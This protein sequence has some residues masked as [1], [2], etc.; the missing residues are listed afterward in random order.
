MTVH[1]DVEI[2]STYLDRELGR[3]E[4]SQVEE[5]LERCDDCREKLSGLQK[6]V[7]NLQALERLAPPQ[8]LGTHLHRLA[9]LE[10]CQPTL[11]QRLE[12]RVSRFSLQPSVAPIFAIVVALIVIIYM[13]SW[14]LHRQATGRIPVHLE[15]EVTESATVEGQGMGSSRQIAGRAFT[16][17]AG[18]WIE[19]GLEGQTVA[20]TMSSSDPRA[21]AWLA[22]TPELQE[23][24]ALGD[25]V[26]LM[27][28]DRVVEIRLDT[29]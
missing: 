29:P 2:L 16:L 14:G 25:R 24:T 26:Q 13:L 23:I 17:E 19:E 18:I 11:T 4:Q 6:V 28:G 9:S 1:P 22:D 5:H 10:I 7:K 20:E 21:P 12:Q 15:S 3:R 27:M 8:H